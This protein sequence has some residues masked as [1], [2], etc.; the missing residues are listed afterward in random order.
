MPGTGPS[1]RKDLH[2]RTLESKAV[3]GGLTGPVSGRQLSWPCV[4]VR[5][6]AVPVS[7]PESEGPQPASP[8]G[9]STRCGNDIVGFQLGLSLCHPGGHERRLP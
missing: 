1:R 2:A 4:P 7:K 6:Q 3:A 5:A 9:A 8:R